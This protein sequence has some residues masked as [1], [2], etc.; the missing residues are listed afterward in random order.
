VQEA[1]LRARTE[2]FTALWGA[3]EGAHRA[4]VLMT[5]ARS[6]VEPGMTQQRAAELRQ[7]GVVVHVVGIDDA[8]DDEARGI[9]GDTGTVQLVA[10][11][12]QAEQ[13]VDAIA[14][15]LCQPPPR[16]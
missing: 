6:T 9:A 1:L 5:D 10:D 16:S 2:T 14:Q 13:A 12:L 15:S 3:R 11:R 8:D 7:S 4:L